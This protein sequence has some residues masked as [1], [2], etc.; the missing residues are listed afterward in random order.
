MQEFYNY[1]WNFYIQHMM[2]DDAALIAKGQL[3]NFYQSVPYVADVHLYGNRI[4][5]SIKILKL[6]AAIKKIYS[7]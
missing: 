5:I 3:W 7:K 4:K 6:W 1:T 2:H